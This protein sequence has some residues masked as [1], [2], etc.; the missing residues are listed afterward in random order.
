MLTVEQLAKRKLGIGGSD[1]AACA[2][3][4]PWKTPVELYI[5]K[6]NPHHES[7]YDADKEERFYWGNQLEPLILKAYERKMNE[8]CLP[9]DE[10]TQGFFREFH[11]TY[12]WMRANID[13]YI[14]NKNIVVEIKTARQNS[15]NLLTPDELR[16]GEA[17][18][19]DMPI[20]YLLQCAHYA[21]VYDA[22]RVDLAV[23]FGGNDFRIYHYHRNKKLEEKLIEKEKIFWHENVLKLIPPEPLDLNDNKLLWPDSFPQTK[24]ASNE[25]FMEVYQLKSLRNRID[26]LEEEADKIKLKIQV[27]MGDHDTLVDSTGNPLTTWKSQISHRTDN[28]LLKKNYPHICAQHVKEVKSRVFRMAKLDI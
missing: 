10:N 4:C 7:I 20:H 15:T 8:K 2:G 9:L 11:P 3:K 6:I 5:E 28:A 25:T 26:E 22:S 13:G 14:L 27:E 21:I 19:D 12:T 17:G 1:A 23:L 24:V 16:W 18:T